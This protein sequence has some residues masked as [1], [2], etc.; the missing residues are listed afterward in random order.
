LTIYLF[1]V[2][3][4]QKNIIK[5]KK[6]KKKEEIKQKKEEKEKKI[7]YEDELFKKMV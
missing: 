4:H 3:N 5:K 2:Q 7:N 1:Q 6:K